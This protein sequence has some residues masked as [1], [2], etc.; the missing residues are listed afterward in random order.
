M[1]PF[2]S[3]VLGLALAAAPPGEAPVEDA[4][5]IDPGPHGC[6]EAS[7]VRDQIVVWIERETISDRLEIEVRAD[8][9][10]RN[11]VHLAIRGDGETLVD[12]PFEPVPDDCDATH[13]AV[14]LAVAIALDSTV[15]ASFLALTPTPNPQPDSQ[16][17]PDP[18]P[19][20][21][22]NPEPQP[23]PKPK[24]KLSLRAQAVLAGGLHPFFG[25]G[26][27]VTFTGDPAPWLSLRGS[28]EVT[29]GLAAPLADDAVAVTIIDGRFDICAGRVGDKVRNHG[30]LGV[31]A[32]PA[33]SRGL[34]FPG[35]TRAVSPWVAA[36]AGWSFGVPLTPSLSLALDLELLV[37]VSKPRPVITDVEGDVT[38]ALDLPPV[39]GAF[40]IGL[41]FP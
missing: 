18:Q 29:Q 34:S 22:P 21:Q 13:A 31:A 32:G 39:G 17:Q 19:Q 24:P 11:I 5:L 1:I 15:L 12:R 41:S 26:G 35:A 20:P 37:P 14:G 9:D 16:P 2:G 28:A 4:L 38:E 8:P 3:R 23:R 6:L 25:A 7:G 40:A 30:C 10:D 33:V 27:R 36:I